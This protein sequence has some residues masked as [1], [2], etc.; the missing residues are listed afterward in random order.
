MS[1]KTTEYGTLEGLSAEQ[2]KRRCLLKAR[3]K[4]RLRDF[5]A[6]IPGAS[7]DNDEI[8]Q[9]AEQ[10]VELDGG[11]PAIEPPLA[12]LIKGADQALADLPGAK[13]TVEEFERARANLKKAE[14][15]AESHASSPE[16]GE[17]SHENA[18]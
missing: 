14:P 11:A 4:R 1:T 10:F 13:I 17:E 16:C 6:G 3:W 12:L 8:D 5:I 9:I 2:A 15:D 7:L 18:D